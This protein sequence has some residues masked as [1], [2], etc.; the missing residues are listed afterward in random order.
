MRTIN[1]TVPWPQGLH[2]RAASKLV[3]VARNFRSQIH[4]QLNSTDADAR[5][6]LSM[7]MLSAGLGS[8]LSIHALG[9]DEHDAIQALQNFFTDPET[10]EEHPGITPDGLTA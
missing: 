1:V 2:L 6:V 5:S 9:E 4:L 7:L 10:E 8:Q 3:Q